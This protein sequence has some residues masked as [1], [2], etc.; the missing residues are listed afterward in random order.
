MS[1]VAKW[2]T[3]YLINSAWQFRCLRFAPR[4]W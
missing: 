3:V 1:D 2:L 4:A